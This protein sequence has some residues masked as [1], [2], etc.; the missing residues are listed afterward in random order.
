W[1]SKT[2]SESS[3]ANT[4]FSRASEKS[5]VDVEL[6]VEKADHDMSNSIIAAQDAAARQSEPSHCAAVSEAGELPIQAIT[7]FSKVYGTRSSAGI[8]RAASNSFRCNSLNS[9]H[10]QS[11][12]RFL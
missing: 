6:R 12:R 3:A 5:C 4:V 10:V 1:E 2:W 7:R 11:F 9:I 8:D